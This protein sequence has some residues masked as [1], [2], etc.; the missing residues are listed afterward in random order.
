MKKEKT[1]ITMKSDMKEIKKRGSRTGLKCV[2]EGC[3]SRA[4]EILPV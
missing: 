1:L 2:T 4:D 3:H